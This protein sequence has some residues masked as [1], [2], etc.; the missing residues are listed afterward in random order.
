MFV[1]VCSHD[2]GE[3]SLPILSFLRLVRSEANRDSALHSNFPK[4]YAAARAE[5]KNE[6]AKNHANPLSSHLTQRVANTPLHRAT[7][8][9]ATSNAK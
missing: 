6:A 9:A 4:Q 5:A 3:T 7:M 8:L 1:S 2:Y